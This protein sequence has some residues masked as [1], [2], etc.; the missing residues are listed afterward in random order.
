MNPENRPME[1]Q[2]MRYWYLVE[3]EEQTGYLAS[4]EPLAPGP[5]QGTLQNVMMVEEISQAEYEAAT[6]QNARMPLDLI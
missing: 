6:G 4:I 2:A 1:S 5:Q 3:I